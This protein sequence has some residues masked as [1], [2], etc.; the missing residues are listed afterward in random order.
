LFGA[1]KFLPLDSASALGGALARHEVHFARDA[2]DAIYRIDSAAR[3]YDVIFCDLARGDLPGPEL[4]GY[5]SISRS[6]AAK[7]MI[8]VAS[9]PLGPETRKFLTGVPNVCIDLPLDAEALHMLAVRRASHATVH[10][11][12]A[13]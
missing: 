6:S 3:P 7:R 5:L 2:F 13:A 1:F 9:G 10:E 8:F 11:P 4:W 12:E